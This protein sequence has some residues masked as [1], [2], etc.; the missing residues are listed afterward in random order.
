MNCTL[1]QV[2]HAERPAPV[3]GH[4]D[5]LLQTERVHSAGDYVAMQSK[6]VLHVGGLV[7]SAEAQEVYAI[8]R[9]PFAAAT[10]GMTSRHT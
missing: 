10:A 7:G 5:D 3:L 4:Q 2:M 1:D 9:R 8:H 6:R